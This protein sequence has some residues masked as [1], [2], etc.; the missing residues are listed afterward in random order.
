MINYTMK[1]RTYR[2]FTDEPLYPF[3]Y[4]LSYTTFQYSNLVLPDTIEAGQPLPVEL[5]VSNTG[6]FDSDEVRS[7]HLICKMYYI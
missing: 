1:E 5:S 2:Y 6:S 4:G 3:G 7:F